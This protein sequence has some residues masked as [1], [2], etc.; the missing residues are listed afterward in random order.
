MSENLEL[1][2]IWDHT[3]KKI[4]NYDLKSIMGNKIKER[5]VF[6]KLEDFN[7]LL[8]YTDDDFTPIGNLCYINENGKTLPTTTLQEFYNL[9]WNIQH[10]I[11]ENEYQ[12]ADDEW[13][14]P[15]MKA[16]DIQNKQAFH[17]ICK[18]HFTGND[19]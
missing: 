6:N 16:I 19:S 11:N 4:L 18:F 7:S 2:Y 17:E 13:T 3:I 15:L 14:N 10:V 12:Y 8:K 5:I 1:S 9:R